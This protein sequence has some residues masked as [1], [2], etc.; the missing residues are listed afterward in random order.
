MK[1]F[2]E[3][4]SKSPC[5][6]G[7][8]TVLPNATSGGSTGLSRIA[9][10]EAGGGAGDGGDDGA[11]GAG[12]GATGGAEVW[13]AARAAPPRHTSAIR[14]YGRRPDLIGISS[15]KKRQSFARSL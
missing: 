14:T 12:G 1:E 15:R 8:L 13:Q 4:M 7:R 5:N 11:D 10:P 6:A 9:G 3:K 2:H